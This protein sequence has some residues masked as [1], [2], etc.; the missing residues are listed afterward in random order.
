M[1]PAWAPLPAHG[2]ALALKRLYVRRSLP[3]AVLMNQ[4]KFWKLSGECTPLLVH[5][6]A[7][8]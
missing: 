3:L 1:T 6:H 8:A 7:N 4:V 5:A 2:P